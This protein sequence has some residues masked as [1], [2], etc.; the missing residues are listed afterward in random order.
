MQD[1]LFHATFSHMN[2]QGID[3]KVSVLKSIL[4]KSL[5]VIGVG[6]VAGLGYIG[7]QNHLES[8]NQKAAD[9][10][11]KAYEMELSAS[12]EA[13]TPADVAEMQSFNAEKVAAWEPTKLDAYLK[14]LAEIDENYS[15]TP[16][17]ALS[18]IRRAKIFVAQKNLSEAETIYRR[19]IS[20]MSRTPLYFGMAS[21]ALGVLLEDQDLNDKALE[22]FKAAASNTSNPLRPLSMLGEAR[23]LNALGKDGAAKIYD[24][25]VK[26]FPET[27]YS[28]RAKALRSTQVSGAR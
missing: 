13:S 12:N 1:S 14:I 9:A 18:Q 16:T 27:A 17:W 15:G 10:F 3:E 7:Y 8:K 20:Q 19:V 25:I 5:V 11:F 21:D 22:V 26:E 24:Q 4:I 6:V 23:A 28:R 2:N